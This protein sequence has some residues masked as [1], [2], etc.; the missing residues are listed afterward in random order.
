MKRFIC[1]TLVALMLLS[2][3]IA[4]PLQPMHISFDDVLAFDMIPGGELIKQER[5]SFSYIPADGGWFAVEYLLKAADLPNEMTSD[6][7][8]YI[9][10]KCLKQMESFYDI[11]Y[12]P[13]HDIIQTGNNTFVFHTQDYSKDIKEN[14]GMASDGYL[15][16][17]PKGIVA[18]WFTSF[19][20][21]I[22]QDSFVKT[23]LRSLFLTG[24]VGSQQPVLRWPAIDDLL[25]EEK[26]HF[27]FWNCEA[28]SFK[29]IARMPY[30]YLGKHAFFTGKVVQVIENGLNT[31]LRIKLNDEYQRTDDILYVT[32]R[33]SDLRDSRILDD[34]RVTVYGV[35]DGLETY[36]TVLNAQASIPRLIAKYIHLEDNVAAR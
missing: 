5:D 20:D 6:N 34:D 31:I 22:I 8:Y 26:L 3:A 14:I 23:V 29:Q 28:L 27:I 7:N 36:N 4:A 11:C 33:R 15:L 2:V 9:L 32:Y 25:A 21:S 35:L 24:T 1:L 12:V 17:T 30:D 10:R 13:R 18:L 19:P 16:W